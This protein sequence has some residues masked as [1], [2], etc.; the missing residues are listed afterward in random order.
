MKVIGVCGIGQMGAAAAVAF[1][2]AGY[3]V[4]GA[5]PYRAPFAGPL[6]RP[7]ASYPQAAAAGEAMAAR[8]RRPGPS[9]GA[10]SGRYFEGTLA[11]CGPGTSMLM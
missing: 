4:L 1:Q 10:G 11:G 8:L 7:A 5:G 2:R 9:Q 6:T 3:R